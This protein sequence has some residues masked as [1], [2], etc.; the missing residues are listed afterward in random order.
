[1]TARV[2]GFGPPVVE[3]PFRGIEDEAV[4]IERGVTVVA[5]RPRAAGGGGEPAAI[6]THG[7]PAEGEDELAMVEGDAD[8]PAHLPSLPHRDRGHRRIAANREGGLR[9]LANGYP[10]RA[11]FL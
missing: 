9:M 3:R 8:R 5:A 6:L 10:M 4:Q 1:M 7:I 11:S 2:S